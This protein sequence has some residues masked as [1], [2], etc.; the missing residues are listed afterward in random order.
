MVFPAR[1]SQAQQEVERVCALADEA[2]SVPV[3]FVPDTTPETWS[4][5]RYGACVCSNEAPFIA[6]PSARNSSRRRRCVESRS[7]QQTGVYLPRLTASDPPALFLLGSDKRS[8][9]GRILRPANVSENQ[10]RGGWDGRDG[11]SARG[12][13]RASAFESCEVQNLPGP[14]PGPRRL[15]L[16][17][18]VLGNP[19]LGEARCFPC[20]A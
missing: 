16:A 3:T 1:F 14:V 5:E 13:G 17:L 18:Q 12:S 9:K 4:V 15:G 10:A 6:D 11:W 8:V 20:G 2:K 19:H 7:L